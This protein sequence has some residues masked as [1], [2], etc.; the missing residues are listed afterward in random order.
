[1]NIGI[2][3]KQLRKLRALLTP[4]LNSLDSIRSSIS[5]NENPNNT[6]NHGTSNLVG[7]NVE[8]H[9]SK[10]VLE[11][12]C[13]SNITASTR[14][15]RPTVSEGET[16]TC[17]TSRKSDGAQFQGTP[18]PE[19]VASG[20][21]NIES[22]ENRGFLRQTFLPSQ[23]LMEQ[24]TRSQRISGTSNHMYIPLLLRLQTIKPMGLDISTIHSTE[25]LGCPGRCVEEE[26]R[27]QSSKQNFSDYLSSSQFETGQPSI[28][29]HESLNKN[30]SIASER[31]SC[32]SNGGNRDVF[33]LIIP[34]DGILKDLYM[35]T[36][37]QSTGS[38]TQPILSGEQIGQIANNEFPFHTFNSPNAKQMQLSNISTSDINQPME[39]QRGLVG[40]RGNGH[41]GSRR[42]GCSRGHNR[43]GGH[44]RGSGR[45]PGRGH[46]RGHG[47]NPSVRT[48]NENGPAR[49]LEDVQTGCGKGA[50]DP[51]S[52][53][54]FV[55]SDLQIMASN[56]T[57]V[58][59]ALGTDVDSTSRLILS[60]CIHKR[61]RS[62]K[63]WDAAEHQS[64][65]T[66]EPRQNNTA[67]LSNQKQH[68]SN[69]TTSYHHWPDKPPDTKMTTTTSVNAETGTAAQ[70]KKDPTSD[71]NSRKRH[72]QIA[73]ESDAGVPDLDTGHED[74]E[75][76][77]PIECIVYEDGEVR[78]NNNP[79]TRVRHK[80]LNAKEL[81]K[82]PTRAPQPSVQT[83]A[84]RSVNS[85]TPKFYRSPKIPPRGRP[86]KN[87]QLGITA[88]VRSKIPIIDS[89]KNHICLIPPRGRPRKI[90]QLENTVPVDAEI[91]IIDSPEYTIRGQNNMP[92]PNSLKTILPAR[93][94]ET[95]KVNQNA[96]DQVKR[97]CYDQ[98]NGQPWRKHLAQYRPKQRSSISISAHD[99]AN[100][101]YVSGPDDEHPL[102][103][104]PEIVHHRS[105]IHQCTK[106]I[107]PF[108]S[109][110][111]RFVSVECETKRKVSFSDDLEIIPRQFCMKKRKKSMISLENVQ[112]RTPIEPLTIQM[113]PMSSK[114]KRLVNVSS[115]KKRKRPLCLYLPISADEASRKKSRYYQAS[116][117]PVVNNGADNSSSNETEDQLMKR[118]AMQEIGR[119]KPKHD[120]C[121]EDVPCTIRDNDSI[122]IAFF[123]SKSLFKSALRSDQNTPHPQS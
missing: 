4:P 67:N 14:K 97:F 37:L 73:K 56:P 69:N 70:S 44:S 58:H 119:A 81:P 26:Q 113:N 114:P 65:L 110:S 48:L 117:V 79:N 107:C 18:T 19:E 62:R 8:G 51:C 76:L 109:T 111:N 83:V 41:S 6:A 57:V 92:R 53:Q 9:G 98:L 29:N 31:S 52:S 39:S 60:Q 40:G 96:T 55:D 13:S 38:V 115:G 45:A 122:P 100:I 15:T 85:G 27:L 17:Q 7:V 54:T 71:I 35:S 47:V 87:R 21:A 50:V 121:E 86:R 78:L 3:D 120:L 105:L 24:D 68:I 36:P 23:W 20:T 101:K 5:D 33:D 61:G 42:R 80:P 118:S 2:T 104:P 91:R 10:Q 84:I 102:N 116:P 1:M 106:Q 63:G 43:C 12:N 32:L 34:D 11:G 75:S 99:P 88:P 95:I 103:R 72:V 82:R 46:G 123:E 59:D 66:R 108:S 112:N 25:T 94:I 64:H 74:T 93:N 16:P 90:R 89:P 22:V 28:S 49:D 30:Q 77:E